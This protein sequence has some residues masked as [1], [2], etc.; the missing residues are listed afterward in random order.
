MN[1]RRMAEAY[2]ENITDTAKSIKRGFQ[3]LYKVYD[4]RHLDGLR[5]K[6]GCWEVLLSKHM[7]G[8]LG[9]LHDSW[10]I[11]CKVQKSIKP[12]W[13]VTDKHMEEIRLAEAKF[14]AFLRELPELIEQALTRA[15]RESGI[16]L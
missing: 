15:V 11:I 9:N 2:R 12:D 6:I 1:I 14:D 13:Q 4:R 8:D 3:N 7:G 5:H 10:Q 16:R